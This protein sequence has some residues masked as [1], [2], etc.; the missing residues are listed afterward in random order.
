MQLEEIIVAYSLNNMKPEN[1]LCG[2][3]AEFFVVK[4]GDP[5]S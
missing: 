2:Q 1:S 5:C 4:G 3:N